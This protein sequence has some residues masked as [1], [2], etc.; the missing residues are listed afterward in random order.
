M[1]CT[2]GCT[3]VAPHRLACADS[4]QDEDTDNICRVDMENLYGGYE[5]P[6]RINVAVLRYLYGLPLFAAHDDEPVEAVDVWTWHELCIVAHKL[7]VVGLPTHALA[8]LEMYF[9]NK[10]E[11]D[12]KTGLLLDKTK[13]DWF[14]RE[15]DAIRRCM[16]TNR[17]TDVID[18]VLKFCCRHYTEFEPNERFQSLTESLPDL[19]RDMLRYGARQKSDFLR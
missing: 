1:S 3:S 2:H 16:D 11:V 17:R 13:I 6:A 15:V 19:H 12:A 9:E 18:M 10:M 5:P 4:V 7:G 8:Q 14:M